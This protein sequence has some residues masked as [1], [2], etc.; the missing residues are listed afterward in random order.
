MIK[1]LVNKTTTANKK[2]TIIERFNNDKTIKKG[3]TVY[4]T[5]KRELNESKKNAIVLE[6]Q[7]S[8]KSSNTL[9]ETTI[10]Q[11]NTKNPSLDLMERM[12][13]LFK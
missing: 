4:E 6:K 11:N 9:N 5:I 12:D 3:K 1:I 13:N 10:Y 2:K 8:A 7:I